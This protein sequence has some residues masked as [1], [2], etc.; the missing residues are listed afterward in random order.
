VIKLK[1]RRFVLN[2]TKYAAAMENNG[3][4][5]S[6]FTKISKG[7]MQS[8]PTMHTNGPI[9]LIIEVIARIHLELQEE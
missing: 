1:S 5:R 9:L 3:T 2:Q 4:S 7:E 8:R 6:V